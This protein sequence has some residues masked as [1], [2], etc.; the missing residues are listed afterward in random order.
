[1]MHQ[2]RAEYGNQQA[3]V[4]RERAL[5]T[6]LGLLGAVDD[7]EADELYANNDERRDPPAE[8]LLEE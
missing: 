4:L 8:V 2:R 3:M 5:R 7:A 1:M 6:H